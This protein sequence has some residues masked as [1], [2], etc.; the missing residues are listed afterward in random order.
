L[1]TGSGRSS[2]WYAEPHAVAVALIIA[3]VLALVTGADCLAGPDD[4]PPVVVTAKTLV[5]NNKTHTVTYSGDVMVTRGT[6]T[7]SAPEVVIRFGESGDGGNA[8]TDGA[9]GMFGGSMQINSIQAVGG[10]RVLQQDK[11]ATAD[12]AIYNTRDDTIVMEGS[13]RVWQGSNVLTGSK[14]T[15][16]I[17]ND[18]ITVENARTIIYTDGPIPTK[19]DLGPA[20]K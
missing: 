6:V 4:A 9:E 12:R 19:K 11:T 17:G 14:I 7:L 1:S 2:I 20:T 10:V 5:A 16:D 8:G 3:A 18:T 15:Y 13:P